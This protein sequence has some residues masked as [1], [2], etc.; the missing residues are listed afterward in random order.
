MLLFIHYPHLLTLQTPT[1]SSLSTQIYTMGHI[2]LQKLGFRQR[3]IR[4]GDMPQGFLD[5]PLRDVAHD[6]DNYLPP[7]QNLHLLRWRRGINSTGVND[8]PTPVGHSK[9]SDTWKTRE[10]PKVT[11]AIKPK[12]PH[13]LSESDILMSWEYIS[14]VCCILPSTSYDVLT[15]K[16]ISQVP[17]ST[18]WLF[19]S[20]MKLLIVN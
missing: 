2:L 5:A 16:I 3:P 10:G 7:A 14:R 17:T 1:L 19:D 11:G 18:I 8:P 6:L 15:G 9:S 4:S 12:S 13:A 20:T